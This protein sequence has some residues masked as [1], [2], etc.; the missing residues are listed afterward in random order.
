MIRSTLY[1]LATL[2]LAT[3]FGTI[4]T[5][6]TCPS[7]PG[8]RPCKCSKDFK[9]INCENVGLVDIPDNIPEPA[10]TLNLGRNSFSVIQR[11]PFVKLKNLT[12][13]DLRGS[14]LR[15]ITVG[16]FHGLVNLKILF[17]TRNSLPRIEP[18]ICDDL[19]MLQ[20]LYLGQNK[21]S[22]IPDLGKCRDL[23]TLLLELNALTSPKFPDSFHSLTK[24]KSVG[25]SNN[26]LG[27]IA[28]DDFAPLLNSPITKIS[29][30]RDRLS[31]IE[32][33][34]FHYISDTLTSLKISYN[35]LSGEDIRNLCD[36][37]GKGKQ[38]T[39]LNFDGMSHFR[40]LPADTFRGFANSSL[41][42]LSFRHT[43]SIEKLEEGTFVYLPK[44][45]RLDIG[46]SKIQQIAPMAFR[47]LESLEELILNQ[48]EISGLPHSLP[49][50]LKIVNLQDNSISKISDNFFAGMKNLWVL[51]LKN[52]NILKLDPHAFAGLEHL[53][54]LNLSGNHIDGAG[55]QVFSPLR[56][57]RSLSLKSNKITKI[58][59]NPRIFEK[60][61]SLEYLDLSDNR[62]SALPA[63]VF[64]NLK[65]LKILRLT[66][67]DL[68]PQL[69]KDTKGELF[70]GLEN[71]EELYIEKN[72]IQ[73]LT[74]DV[75]RH[76]KGAKMLELGENAISQWG[77][78]TFL[79]QNSTLKHL[80]LSRNRIATINEPS[81]ADLKLLTTLTLTANPFSCDCGLVW[82]R[83]W[84]N[85]T[86]V[87][88]PELE[89]YTCN[90][91]VNMAGIP[92][93]KFD[94]DSLTCK[95]LFPYI[96][97][98]SLGG[99]VILILVISLV[100]YRYRW[101]I[102]L[103]A[104]RIA[105]AVARHTRAPGYEPIPGDDLRFDAYISN[106]R[107]DR[108]FV[109][110]EL[111]QNYDNGNGYNG[112]FRLCF[113][114]RD[115][116]PGEYDLTNVTENMSQ[117]QRGLIVLS[118][119][120]IQDHFQDFELHLLLKEANLRAFGLIVIELEEIPPNRI[121]NGLRRIFEEGDHLSWSEDPNQQQL[122]RERL[123]NK[124]QRRPQRFVDAMAP[125]VQD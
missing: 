117:S 124:L 72:D 112:G 103:R 71:L 7:T 25:L 121:P 104:Y 105:K 56:K 94:P 32:A 88:F 24:L 30:S 38:F 6:Y 97:G 113:N 69:R 78:S 23:K 22:V 82:F 9:N 55:V 62:C 12:Q 63:L 43:D 50:S 36:D 27:A 77:T 58:I 89:L 48:N 98:G 96:L 110:D 46:Y 59:K 51:N 16:A 118:L 65:R 41:R 115:F 119:Q 4:D 61:A 52:N 76:L 35:S 108:R 34:S 81:L 107:D 3:R 49:I 18:S 29:L 84:I 114:E 75:F 64:Q 100:M 14:Q 19:P 91:P 17:L 31:S 109:L 57:L 99:F 122:F 70:A 86:N 47:G 68:G 116:V 125:A 93:L 2:L 67:N 79:S 101:F 87:T 73:E 10:E 60:L 39:S 106:H 33:G 53:R 44:L 123:T 1:L 8:G 85:S 11:G 102:K 111:L 54:Y 21:L 20:D 66:N 5:S 40:D 74:G 26:D 28:K 92:L 37:L 120:Y 45:Y 95:D 80:N 15:T 42:Q 83:R 90:S 13:L